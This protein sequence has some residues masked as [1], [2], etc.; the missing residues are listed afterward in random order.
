MTAKERAKIDFGDDPLG[1]FSVEDW[2]VSTK[3]GKR[4]EP[5]TTAKVAEAAGFRSREPKKRAQ[6]AKTK[7]VVRRRRTGRNAQLNLRLKQEDIDEFAAIADAQGW[8][9]G[10]TFEHALDALKASLKKKS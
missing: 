2:P 8:V 1:D 5:E 4:P 10:E 3:P 6:P 9:L 7:S